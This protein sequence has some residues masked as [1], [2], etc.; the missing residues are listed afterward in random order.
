MTEIIAE[1]LI[2]S[3]SCLKLMTVDFSLEI[4]N[5]NFETTFSK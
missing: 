3:K 4:T 2:T 5:S 1:V